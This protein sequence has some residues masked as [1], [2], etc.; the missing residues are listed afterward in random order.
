MT[1]GDKSP[2]TPTLIAAVIIGGSILAGSWL[3]HSSLNRNAEG[4]E[5]IQTS[6]GGTKQAIEQLAQAQPRQQPQQRRRGPDPN[7]RYTINT[8]GA[9]SKGPGGAKVTLVEFS[10]FQ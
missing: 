1:T 8:S 2:L 7:R 3:I 9:P 5:G 6:L 10:D 4:L